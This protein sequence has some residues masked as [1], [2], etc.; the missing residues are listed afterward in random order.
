MTG[1]IPSQLTSVFSV[2][3]FFFALHQGEAAANAFLV[4]FLEIPYAALLAA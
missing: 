3:S 4:T 2:V 1:A